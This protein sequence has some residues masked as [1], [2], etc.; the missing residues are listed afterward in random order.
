MTNDVSD[1]AR[2]AVSIEVVE[3]GIE[4]PKGGEL[5]QNRTARNCGLHRSE[6]DRLRLR[7]ELGAA[8]ADFGFEPLLLFFGRRDLPA[9]FFRRGLSWRSEE[10]RVGKGCRAR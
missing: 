1:V 5:D 6:G 3:L 2:L 4:W 8:P 10:R 9:K 7:S